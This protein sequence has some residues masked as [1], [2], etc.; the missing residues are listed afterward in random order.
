MKV[1]KMYKFL[2]IKEIIHVHVIYSMMTILKI[3]ALAVVMPSCS[4]ALI[5]SQSITRRQP[6]TRQNRL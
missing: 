3:K 6:M 1:I 2:V 5:P 4:D